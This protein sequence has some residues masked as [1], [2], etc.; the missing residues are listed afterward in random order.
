M[1]HQSIAT[2]GQRRAVLALTLLLALPAF[3]DEEPPPN[4]VLPEDSQYATY[5]FAPVLSEAEYD[6]LLALC[7]LNTACSIASIFFPDYPAHIFSS[8]LIGVEANGSMVH[9]AGELVVE[10][11]MSLGAELGLTGTYTLS[12]DPTAKLIA[13]TLILGAVGTGLVTQQGGSVAATNVAVGSNGTTTSVYTMLGG[14]FL[15][16]STTVGSSAAGRVVQSGGAMSFG[17]L[18]IGA[19]DIGEMGM[20][21]G[22]AAHSGNIVILGKD[23][24]GFGTLTVDDTATFSVDGDI[25]A[26][27]DGEGV[28]VQN[29]GVVSAFT[30]RLGAESGGVGSYELNA[31]ELQGAVRVGDAGDGELT[32][33]GGVINGIG[34]AIGVEEN[35]T[36]SVTRHAGD[37]TFSSG[38][39][40]GIAGTGTYSQLGGSTVISGGADVT[41]G[42]HKLVGGSFV[43]GNGTLEIFDGVFTVT[44]GSM[45]VGREGNGTVHQ[46]NNLVTIGGDLL[47]AN[48]SSST[49]SYDVVDST[50]SVGGDLTVGVSG[51]GTFSQSLGLVNVGN[52]IRLG[53]FLTA[54]GTW[55]NSSGDIVAAL[56]TIGENGIGTLNGSGTPDLGITGDV[57]LGLFSNGVG[58]VDWQGGSFGVGDDLIIGFNG[59][60]SFTADGSDISVGDL[61]VLGENG[62]STGTLVMTGGVLDVAT[63]YQVGRLGMGDVTQHSGAVTVTGD[64]VLADD[65]AGANG[66][67]RLHDGQLDTTDTIVADEGIGT[68]LQSGGAHTITGS[69]TLGNQFGSDGFYSISG[70]AII[71]GGDIDIGNV[72]AGEFVQTD[73]DTDIGD[74]LELGASSNG[75][76]ILDISGG[77]IDV[78]DDASIGEFGTGEVHQSDG[79]VTVGDTLY[80]GD[81][82]VDAEGRYLL[83]GGTL[84]TGATIVGDAGFGEFTHNGG[85]HTT[86]DELDIG[87]ENG[88]EGIYSLLAGELTVGWFTDVGWDGVG[89]FTQTGGTATIASDLSAGG[90]A[91]GDGAITVSGGI[92]SVGEDLLLGIQG[93]GHMTVDGGTITVL[94]DLILGDDD[95]GSGTLVVSNGQIDVADDLTVGGDGTGTGLVQHSGGLITANELELGDDGA[96]ASGRYE[97]SGTASL[98]LNDAFVGDSGLGEL[99]LGGGVVTVA[100]TLYVG[101]ASTSSGSLSLA[102]GTLTSDVTVVGY[103]GVGALFQ[104]GGTHEVLTRLELGTMVGTG[105]Y[106]LNGGQLLTGETVV[107]LAG[108]ADFAHTGGAH[109]T[110]ALTVDSGIH[111]EY[112]M[113]GNATLDATDIVIGENQHGVFDQQGGSV[114]VAE[115]LVLGRDPFGAGV[116]LLDDGDLQSSNT[117]VGFGGNGDFSQTGGTHT[118]FNGLSL[119]D[120]VGGAG[121]YSL[122]DGVL[123][124]GFTAIGVADQGLFTQSGGEHRTGELIVHDTT[125][126]RYDMDGGTLEAD[127]LVNR[128]TINYAG[129]TI[130]LAVN[131]PGQL[132]NEGI[133]NITT[134]DG[135]IDGDVENFGSVILVDA[136]VE[137]TGEFVNHGEL[138]SDPSTSIYDN[139]T[140]TTDGYL[141]GGPGDRFVI[142]G[143]LH[144]TSTNAGAWQTVQ[145]SLEFTPGA[146]HAFQSS[147]LDA[148]LDPAGYANNFAWGELILGAGAT[149]ALSGSALYVERLFLAAGSTLELLDFQLY[150][151]ELINLGT[152][153][154]SN[155]SSLNQL[156]NVPLPAPIGLLLTALLWLARRARRVPAPAR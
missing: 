2:R 112:V 124:T 136:M 27:E 23:S 91:S 111:A 35:S 107:G 90:S 105:S 59:S 109:H 24:N 8:V 99:V 66:T 86:V 12:D 54:T 122:D 121:S 130:A 41:L 142:A 114:V 32:Q 64:L 21:Q 94:D 34:L 11:A 134:V 137:F 4:I 73:G 5:N 40:I 84:A 13:N 113:S 61:L 117:V 79:A 102:G 28:I 81:D 38:I 63:E 48:N 80:L 55:N 104:D 74:D 116:W 103:D 9:E 110:S 101:N 133:L 65:A 76:G 150:F 45:F 144:S 108:T 44:G 3:A 33:F 88:S 20:S 92:L 69:L 100:S 148:G 39:S 147:G 57:E 70:G 135:L 56:A 139:L 60:G 82:A 15:G 18:T 78:V 143:D 51:D 154:G 153:A 93:L 141:V 7:D 118:A 152:I 106:E 127:N 146:A 22:A 138:N 43:Q 128:G 50:L 98:S 49:A 77:T 140:V 156:S 129:G 30:T 131:G 47:I 85:S 26:G 58:T 126:T 36:G 17:T 25:R 132:L 62:G 71:T 145:A 87:S 96:D 95:T 31:G 10:G 83:S 14:E 37:S 151:G 46:S 29:G 89:T 52:I 42:Q 115:A 75:T 67:Y 68:F 1:R 120:E 123:T 155:G 119:T 149:L 6:L 72:G 16:V 53:H 125:D 97:I 19:N